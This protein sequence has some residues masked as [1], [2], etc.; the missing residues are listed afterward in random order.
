M[1]EVREGKD[2]IDVCLGSDY[3]DKDYQAEA[4]CDAMMHY[5]GSQFTTKCFG[6]EGLAAMVNMSSQGKSD[7]E[8]VGDLDSV[9]IGPDID[10]NELIEQKTEFEKKFILKHRSL[11]SGKLSS[12]RYIRA[13]PMTISIKIPLT[14]LVTRRSIVLNTLQ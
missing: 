6:T 11:F 4:Y 1:V 7:D 9:D 14:K 3:Q 12:S 13:P 8:V 2:F 10:E 5:L